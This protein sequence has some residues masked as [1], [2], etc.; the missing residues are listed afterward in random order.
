MRILHASK[1]PP[2]SQFSRQ[3]APAARPR[4]APLAP[5]APSHPAAP[6][7]PATRAAAKRGTREQAPAGVRNASRHSSTRMC[8]RKPSQHP[9]SPPTP[10]PH[11]LQKS[12]TL[13][14]GRARRRR[15]ATAAAAAV[16]TPPAAAARTSC[17]RL[18]P[19]ARTRRATLAAVSEW[20]WTGRVRSAVKHASPSA[21]ALLHLRSL[22]SR[23]ALSSPC[24]FFL[25]PPRRRR[26]RGRHGG[27]RQ[28]K[29][30][31]GRRGGG[32]CSGGRG[33]RSGRQ[34]QRGQQRQRGRG[35]ATLRRQ[36]FPG[37]RQGRLLCPRLCQNPRHQ[38]Q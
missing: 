38:R 10:P 11:H 13:R 28:R 1:Q 15:R 20:G 22:S 9:L 18:G 12:R 5:G 33:G 26:R 25:P 23:A 27:R 19:R 32:G 21:C 29:R 4:S 3:A 24:S 36:G 31:R 7:K 2:A 17:C 30:R 35:A 14:R 34:R 6:M 8:A 16:T 37:G